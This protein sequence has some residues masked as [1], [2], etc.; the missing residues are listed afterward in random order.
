MK[1]KWELFKLTLTETKTM[2]KKEWLLTLA[3]CI[4]SGIVFGMLVSPRKQVT[5][6]SHN[7]S[8]NQDNNNNNSGS[9]SAEL[10]DLQDEE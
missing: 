7:G 4:L 6:G 2:T 3:V 9:V 10:A 1:E 5:I 8:N